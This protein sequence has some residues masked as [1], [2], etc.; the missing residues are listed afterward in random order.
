MKRPI[1]VRHVGSLLVTICLMLTTTPGRASSQPAPVAGAPSAGLDSRAA[2]VAA[3]AITPAT[4]LPPSTLSAIA[5]SV[6]EVDLA[7]TP[8]TAGR[9][10]SY[11]VRRD[12]RLLATLSASARAYVDITVQ[13]ATTYHYLVEMVD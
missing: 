7:W 4:E 1:S 5:V 6:R 2:A 8:P 3:R 13:P 10:V 12:G 11:A 9:V